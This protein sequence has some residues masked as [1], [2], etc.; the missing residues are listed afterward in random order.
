MMNK[1]DFKAVLGHFPAGV[2]IVTIKAGDAV[3]GCTVSAF[4]S[5]SLEPS[6]IMVAINQDSRSANLLNQPNAT[7]AVNILVSDQAN[8]SDQFA[9]VKT[10]NKFELGE[11]TTAVTQAP[12]LQN[13][14]GWLDCTIHSTHDA[15]THTLYIGQV[16]ACRLVQP[17]QAPLIYWNRGYREL[18]LKS[19]G[20][21]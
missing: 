3:H 4:S 8:I 20:V 1:E 9:W 14:L 13:A 2:T 17:N 19:V 12:I 10:D 15:G 7:F 11:W 16:E 5:I 6:L 18:A 21:V